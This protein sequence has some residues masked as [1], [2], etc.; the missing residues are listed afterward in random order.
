MSV[1]NDFFT[2]P[3]SLTQI[4]NN[5]QYSATGV[6]ATPLSI[7]GVAQSVN[8]GR[9]QIR[10]NGDVSDMYTRDTELIANP[11]LRAAAAVLQPTLTTNINN[12]H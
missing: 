5:T 1:Q 7:Q 2:D 6:G 8:E 3:A 10:I 4:S 12:K 9:R 11:A